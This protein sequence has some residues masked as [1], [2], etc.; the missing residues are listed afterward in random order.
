MHT[1]ANK[2]VIDKNVFGSGLSE[3][4]AITHNKQGIRIFIEAFDRIQFDGLVI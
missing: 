3:Y 2:P 4:F 1:S